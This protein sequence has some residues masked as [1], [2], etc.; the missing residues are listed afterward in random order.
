[1]SHQ[2]SIPNFIPSDASVSSSTDNKKKII[3]SEDFDYY[4]I[5]PEGTKASGLKVYLENGDVVVIQYRHI[6]SPIYF[7]GYKVVVQY[8]SG[9]S[10]EIW[11]D[12]LEP[13]LDYISENR[14]IWIR[15]SPENEVSPPQSEN[16][17]WIESLLYRNPKPQNV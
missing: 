6:A 1:M 7:N 17:I 4:G 2:R 16:T 3:P 9:K 5:T 8:S 15:Q 10:I 14:L 12:N 11:G 13:I